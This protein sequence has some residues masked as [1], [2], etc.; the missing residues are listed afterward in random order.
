MGL[1][2]LAATP[3]NVCAGPSQDSIVLTLQLCHPSLKLINFN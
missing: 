2:G 3:G 1:S